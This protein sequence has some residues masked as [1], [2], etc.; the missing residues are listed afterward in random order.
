[1][2]N[3]PSQVCELMLLITMGYRPRVNHNTMLFTE[4]MESPEIDCDSEIAR[5]HSSLTFCL[6]QIDVS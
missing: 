3:A 5:H 2:I 4:H 6:A 1:M